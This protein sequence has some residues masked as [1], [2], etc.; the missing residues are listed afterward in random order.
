MKRLMRILT[1]SLACAAAVSLAACSN[2]ESSSSEVQTTAAETDATHDEAA[3]DTKT[4]RDVNLTDLHAINYDGNEFAGAWHITERDEGET[5]R[6]FTYVFDGD[7]TCYLM[8]GSM[9]YISNYELNTDINQMATQM[10][11]GINGKYTYE[12]S[13]DN[14]TLTLTDADTKKQTKLEKYMSF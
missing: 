6:S 8:M 4:A 7:S 2:G 5:Y 12:F 10:V 11:F 1:L 13:D 3:S 9:G 14:N